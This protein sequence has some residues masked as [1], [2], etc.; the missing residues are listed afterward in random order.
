MSIKETIINDLKAAMKSGDKDRLSVLRMIKAKILETEVEL[1]TKKGRDY[2]LNDD[3]MIDVL[4]R[5]AKQRR[6]SI[7]KYKEAG[8]NELAE[9]EEAELK[10]VQDYLP[11]QLSTE[12]IT[13]IVK[14][15]IAKSG[16]ASPKDMGKVMQLVVPETK[17]A[18][19]G[20]V[21]SQIVRDLLNT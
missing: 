9:K 2:Q 13:R 3:E 17:G 11:K 12:E 7:E 6:E 1:R 5:Y 14:D 16:A 19:D 21:V 15:A 10:I 4:S 8:R 20:K 18:A